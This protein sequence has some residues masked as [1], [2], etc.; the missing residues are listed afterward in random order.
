MEDK[1][2]QI[3]KESWFKDHVAEYQ[4]LNDEVSILDWGKPRTNFYRVRYVFDRY[5]LFISGDIGEA[6]FR[7]TWNGTPESFKDVNLGYFFSK[8]AAY[9]G[10][11]WDFDSDAAINELHEW[12]ER[13]LEEYEYG[14]EAAD[15]FEDLFRLITECNSVEYW[16]QG[17][18]SEGLYER[19]SEYDC[20]CYEWLFSIGQAVPIRIKGYLI[21]LKMANEQLQK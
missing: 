21:G 4:K 18:L 14:D 16:K 20:D 17:L 1:D 5:M 2:N 13:Y 10:G 6:A 12:Q 9:E 3:I 19:L 7:L 11:K 15:I 8:I